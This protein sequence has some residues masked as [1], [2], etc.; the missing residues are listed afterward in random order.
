M[1]T[2]SGRRCPL[3]AAAEAFRFSRA[4]AGRCRAPFL[5]RTTRIPS[6]PRA[7]R[8]VL[9]SRIGF[10][11]RLRVTRVRT[12]TDAAGI[13][14]LGLTFPRRRNTMRRTQ[15]MADPTALERDEFL[16]VVGDQLPRAMF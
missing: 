13:R 9:V 11:S 12:A 14:V 15:A 2:R 4:S 10:D 1:S 8:A 3:A 7:I 5:M 16:H 6:S